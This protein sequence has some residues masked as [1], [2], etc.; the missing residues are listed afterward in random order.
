MIEDPE[1]HEQAFVETRTEISLMTGYKGLN[2]K[3]NGYSLED[4]LR[5]QNAILAQEVYELRKAR[6]KAAEAL[7][8]VDSDEARQW[9]AENA[10]RVMLNTARKPEELV[11]GE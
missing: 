7:E 1:E 5:Q 2:R 3:A 11:P 9:M 8:D 6:H 4:D 10:H